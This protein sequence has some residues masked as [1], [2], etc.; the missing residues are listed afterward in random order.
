MGLGGVK[1]AENNLTQAQNQ[2]GLMAGQ[3]QQQMANE[4]AQANF[5][6]AGVAIE[7]GDIQAGLMQRQIDITAGQQAESYA[8]GGVLPTQGSPLE[9]INSTRAIGAIQ[10]MA[11]QQAAQEQANLFQTQGYLD[12]QGGL[13][14]LMK[15][16]G[17]TVINNDQN[18]LEQ[19]QQS[20]QQTMGFLG[21]GLTAGIGA[22]GLLKN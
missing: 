11:I 22:L 17:Q 18:K 12:Q 14:D 5:Q 3:Q 13:Q 1:S 20:Y 8:S 4:E 21:M 9:Q 15:A 6:Q 2:F 10:I 16:E 19:A 7:Q